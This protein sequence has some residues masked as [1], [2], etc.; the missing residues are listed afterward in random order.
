MLEERS[1]ALLLQVGNRVVNR[2]LL[3]FGNVYV[4]S[5]ILQSHCSPQEAWRSLHREQFGESAHT[6]IRRLLLTKEAARSLQSET[7]AMTSTPVAS[8]LVVALRNS[9]HLQIGPKTVEM[10]LV[11]V[12]L[13]SEWSRGGLF[14]TSQRVVKMEETEIGE[15]KENWHDLDECPLS[16]QTQYRD[17]YNAVHVE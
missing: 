9:E 5:A 17:D 15:N 3:R 12:S 6:S 14:S 4:L 11:G 8:H 10:V 16:I 7:L 1:S 2:G 13:I